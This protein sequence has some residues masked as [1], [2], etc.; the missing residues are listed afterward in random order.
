MTVNKEEK[1]ITESEDKKEEMAQEAA[2]N[3]EKKNRCG[4]FGLYADRELCLVEGD[5]FNLGL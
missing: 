2:A 3:G 4:M 1:A 5:I